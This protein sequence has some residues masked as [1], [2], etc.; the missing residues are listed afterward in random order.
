MKTTLSLQKLQAA[1]SF[2]LRILMG[3]LFI[4]I[5]CQLAL[6]VPQLQSFRVIFRT[7][8]FSGSLIAFCFI[9]GNKLNPSWNLFLYLSM[10]LLIIN[11]FHPSTNTPAAALASI[12]LNL[13]ILAPA[14][15]VTRLVVTKRTMTTVLYFMWIFNTISCIFGCLQIFYPG[16]FSAE[17][18]SVTKSLGVIADGL[19]IVLSDGSQVWRPTGLSDVPGGAAPAG[20]TAILLSVGIFSSSKNS[21]IRATCI[22]SICTGLF[23]IFLCQVRSVV[24]VM[25]VDL[26]AIAVGFIILKRYWDFAI[27]GLLLPILALGMYFVS[28]GFGGENM[29]SRFES[30]LQ[31]SPGNVYYS[32]R[33]IFLEHTLDELIDKY[34]LGA[35]L[36]RW[37]MMNGYFGNP[38]ELWVEIQWTA[39]VYDGGLPLLVAFV[40]ALA[41]AI[42][43]SWRIAFSA[44]RDH[45]HW[46]SSW[47][48]LILAQNI[49]TVALLFSYAPFVGQVG[50]EFWLLNALLYTVAFQER[51]RLGK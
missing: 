28:S 49:G 44:F 8:A 18:S 34:A 9:R 6:L 48:L 31:Q 43:S 29:T 4:Q 12:L 17:I 33:G 5:V 46:L 13:A 47:A 15:W 39:W 38:D 25:T 36:G 41:C 11:F 37:G 22:G 19:K 14:F 50:M 26:V 23:C 21:Y 35:G 30:L 20:L 24:V 7:A 42:I 10:L 1:E 2:A 40:S 16:Q 32:N 45:N 51:K 27:I 3:F